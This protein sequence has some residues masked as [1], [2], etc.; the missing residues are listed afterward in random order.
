MIDQLYILIYSG[1][2]NGDMFR[3]DIYVFN[4]TSWLSTSNM[5]TQRCGH[6]VSTITWETWDLEDCNN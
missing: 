3:S 2:C 1:G 6:A 4:N 5:L